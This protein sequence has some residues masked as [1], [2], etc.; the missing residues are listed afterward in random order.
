MAM[1]ETIKFIKLKREGKGDILLAIDSIFSIEEKGHNAEITMKNGDR[2]NF[3]ATEFVMEQL[4][5]FIHGNDFDEV[6]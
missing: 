3:Q 4:R 5:P 1:E 6:C 2:Y